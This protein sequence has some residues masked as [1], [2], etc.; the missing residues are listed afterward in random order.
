MVLPDKLTVDNQTQVDFKAND[1][2]A[3]KYNV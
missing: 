2:E 3:T 1:L